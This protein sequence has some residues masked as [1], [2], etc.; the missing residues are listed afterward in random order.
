MPEN[1]IFVAVL[2]G[3]GLIFLGILFRF[4]PVPL[5]IT[6]VFS[7]VR[8]SLVELTV[9]RF[10]KVPPKLI[11]RNM[12]LATKAGIPGIDS[13]VLEAH[14]LANGNLNN[15][16]RALIVAE[17]A[18]LNMDFQEMAAIDLA[19]RDVLRAMQI[20]VTPYIIDVP[21]IVGLARD[22]IQ[23]EAEAFVTV[24]T[25]IHALVGGAGE[26]TII[27]RVGQ[28]IISQIGATNTYL[29]VVENPISL[30]ERILADGL[31]AGTMFEILS[32]D[33]ADIDIGQ[34]IGAQLRIDQAKADL[35]VANAKA[36]KR[37]AQAV[38]HEQEMMAE[39]QKAK[40]KKIE[41]EA[42]LP[43]AISGAFR[44]GQ[45]FGDPVIPGEEESTE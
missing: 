26:E 4:V 13:K 37:R 19:G 38:A 9:M 3:G 29:E 20:S 5:W 45:L 11:V 27:A 32:I 7:G 33:I 6:A 28:G 1:L 34:N 42:V 2:L 41:A 16:I 44:V 36:E 30:T 23:V 12:I 18:N 14:H 35:D 40:A 10:R 17:K 8:I 22:G 25:N 15:V 43:D 24:R 31:D 21:D 39:I